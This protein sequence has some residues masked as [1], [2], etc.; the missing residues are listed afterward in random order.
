LREKLEM[1]TFKDENVRKYIWMQGKGN[2]KGFEKLT[3]RGISVFTPQLIL[4]EI[5]IS[6]THL[7]KLGE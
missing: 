4:K 5:K 2:N 3:Y 7:G 1:K 6:G